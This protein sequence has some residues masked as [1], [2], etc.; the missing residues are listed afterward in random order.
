MFE[1]LRPVSVGTQSFLS[2]LEMVGQWAAKWIRNNFRALHTTGAKHGAAPGWRS[3]VIC[4]AR[5]SQHDNEKPRKH[6]GPGQAKRMQ[7]AHDNHHSL[8]KG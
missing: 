3:Q 1:D 5:N 2:L 8:F 4:V 7:I 6:P